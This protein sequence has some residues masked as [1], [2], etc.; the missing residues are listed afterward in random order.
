LT[1]THHLYTLVPPEKLLL[2]ASIRF[3]SNESDRGHGRSK[4]KYGKKIGFHF[5]M[6]D[7][8]KNRE[9]KKRNEK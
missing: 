6:I 5:G 7:V 9:H 8:K 1:Q 4:Y 3:I 2:D